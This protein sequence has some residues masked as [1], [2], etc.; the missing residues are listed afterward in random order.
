MS[1]IF[2]TYLELKKLNKDTIYLF[3]SGIFFLAIDADAYKLSKIFNFKLGYLT[4]D[5]VKCGFPCSSFQKYF[6]LFK[7]Y[8][9]EIKI[10]E[11]EKNIVFSL[12]N[13]EQNNHIVSLLEFINNVDVNN[14]SVSEAYSL[15]ENLKQKVDKIYELGIVK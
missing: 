2:N 1:K 15:I 8:N 5:I 9:L 10:I 13:F 4:T 12:T 11:L 14:L 7:A 6:N 3:K